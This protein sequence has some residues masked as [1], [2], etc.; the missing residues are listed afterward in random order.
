MHCKIGQELLR[1]HPIRP[2]VVSPEERAPL[3]RDPKEITC[4]GLSDSDG[5]SLQTTW[6]GRSHEL[7][8]NT[9][10]IL[11]RGEKVLE[12]VHNITREEKEALD[13]L[14]KEWVPH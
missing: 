12:K 5:I 7:R 13:G 11:G 6:S 2:R 8:A 4:R 3:C 1:L 14:G 9:V 10:N